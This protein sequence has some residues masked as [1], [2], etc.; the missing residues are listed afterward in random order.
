MSGRASG[1]VLTQ[2][3]SPD[4]AIDWVVISA[5]AL[6]VSLLAGWGFAT[7][8]DTSDPLDTML[9]QTV[10]IT[11]PSGE[12]S[13][14]IVRDGVVL[15]AG[16]VALEHEPVEVTFYDGTTEDFTVAW[17]GFPDIDLAVLVGETSPGTVAT[18]RCELE[19][20]RGENILAIGHPYTLPWITTW[21]R[22]ASDGATDTPRG[23][24]AVIDVT[25]NPGNSGGPI[26]DEQGQLI[27]IVSIVIST[28]VGVALGGVVP[29]STFCNG[30]DEYLG[31]A[32]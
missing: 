2:P 25:L 4:R 30:A 24:L 1:F 32:K 20:Q 19:A 22:V 8:M 5:V 14:V 31:D 29:I 6:C 27:G 23:S 11:V 26:F 9:D 3:N 18:L 15:T 13:G 7:R 28:S 10:Y 16:H 12:G 21:G 17:N